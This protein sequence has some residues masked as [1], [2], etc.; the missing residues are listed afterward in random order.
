MKFPYIPI[1]YAIADVR[2]ELKKRD[3]AGLIDEDDCLN[4]AVEVIREIGGGT[5]ESK[6]I[7]LHVKDNIAVL[8]K[9]FYK[10]QGL[11]LLNPAASGWKPFAGKIWFSEGDTSYITDTMIYPGDSFTGTRYCS[12]HTLASNS[13][14]VTYIV[15]HPNIIRCSLPTCDIGMEY[16]YLPRDEK[17]FLLM[18]DEVHTLKATKAFITSKLLKEDYLDQKVPRYIYKDMEQEYDENVL[19]A[20]SIMKFNDPAD[21]AARGRQQ[22][23]RYDAFKFKNM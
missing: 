22:D 10:I 8:P 19:Q 3:R 15:R 14:D 2:A 7:V 4:W 23:A 13:R 1:S 16:L 17:G 6:P 11:W 21:D 9:D 5:Y 20:Q 18:Q 12:S